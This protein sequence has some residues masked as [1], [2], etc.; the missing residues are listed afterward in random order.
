MFVFTRTLTLV[1]IRTSP[2]IEWG[3]G[4]NVGIVVS[5][6]FGSGLGEVDEEVDVDDDEAALD[7]VAVEV[8]LGMFGRRGLKAEIVVDIGRPAETNF[9]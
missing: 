6:T 1:G 3:A 7:V 4:V 9:I 2:G 8:L 5:W